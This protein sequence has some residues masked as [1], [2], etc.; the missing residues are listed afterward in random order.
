M[1]ARLLVVDALKVIAAQ[2]IVWHHLAFYGP[3]SDHA[4]A[5]AAALFDAL[6]RDARLAVQVFLVVG[7]FLAARQLAPEGHWRGQ[8][9]ALRR[10]GQRYLRL[11]VPYAAMLVV[12]VAAAAVARA[13]M[14]HDSIPAAPTLAQFVAHLLLLQDL[15]G[16][17]ALSAGVWYVAVDFQ[18]YVLLI[19]LLLLARRVGATAAPWLVGAAAAAS[20]LVVNRD[21]RWDIAA[22]YFFGAYALGVLAAWVRPHQ[23]GPLWGLLALGTLAL[24]VEWRSRIALAGATALLLALAADRR[25]VQRALAWAADRSYALFLIHFPVLLVVN[26]AF[27]RWAPPEPTVQLAGMGCA[28]A[29]SLAAAEGLYRLAER[30]AW[31][32]TRL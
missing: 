13:W 2:A 3:M 21:P 22:P 5:L 31:L 12:A 16:F 6:A 29:L 24:W 27:T 11:A 7:G 1:S 10:I 25:H 20:L 26:A 8:Q 17:D 15:L 14:Q 28:W 23:R 32:G 9:P 19:G 4:A 30:R 18:L